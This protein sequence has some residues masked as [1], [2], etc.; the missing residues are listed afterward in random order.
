[1]AEHKKTVSAIAWH[2]KN[3]NILASAS[4][5]NK[6]I[7]W[8]ISKQ[9]AVSI[10]ENTKG[11]AVTIGWCQLNGDMVSYMCGKGPLTLWSYHLPSSTS[12]ISTIKDTGNFVSDVT[13]F[14]WHGKTRE[15]IAIGHKDG[16]VSFCSVGKFLYF[17]FAEGLLMSQA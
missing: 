11:I 3:K 5:E 12:G 16:S 9:K 17:C 8:D 14:R 7:V 13:C 6:I 1:M 10:L 2:P 15:K 4:F